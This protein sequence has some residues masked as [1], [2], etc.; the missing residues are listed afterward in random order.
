M[1]INNI[2][3]AIAQINA[4][5]GDLKGN[6]K[7]IT[8]FLN[9]GNKVGC[10]IILFPELSITGYPP[11]DLLL[12]KQFVKHQKII[13]H[14]IAQHVENFICIVGFVDSDD[15]SLY[16]A[17]AIIFQGQLQHVYRKI[18]L[19]NYSVFD[20][21]RYFEKG[22]NPCVVN[23]NNI[24]IGIS[25]CEDI[26]IPNSVSEASAFAGGAEIIVNISASPYSMEKIK[27]REQ[28]MKTRAQQCFS[29]IVYANLVGG[30]DELVFDGNSLIVDQYG[31][32]KATGAA[33]KQDFIIYDINLD[34]VRQNR[35]IKYYQ[36]VSEYSPHYKKIDNID[37]K[38]MKTQKKNQQSYKQENIKIMSLEEE[39]YFAL[40]LGLHDYVF[41]NG[42]T[43][44]VLGLSGGID[45]AL[46]ATIAA[47]AL[48]AKNVHCVL[49][50]SQYSSQGSV[51]DSKTLA[52]NLG[53]EYSVFP[54]KD[55]F[56][57]YLQL[58]EQIFSDL[59]SDI[60]EEN[61]QARI[62]GNIIMALSNKFGWLALATGN[63]SEVSVGYCTIYG[64]MVG[65]FAPLKDV[66]KTLVYGLSNYRNKKAGYD[67][68]PRSII[69]KAPSAELRP[70]QTDQDSLPPYEI[71]DH[72]L[73]LYIE[74]SLGY[75]E[76]VQSGHNIETVRQV[77]RL[78]DINEY[79]RRQ[80]APGTKITSLAFG[81]DRRMPIT[82]RF[83]GF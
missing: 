59:P 66:N 73:E 39:V 38:Y 67:I 27:E 16:N 76:I 47:D 8:T 58:F 6:K 44:V 53:L 1:T 75:E 49:M 28:L 31:I 68:I 41:K 77:I 78:V 37:I 71:L 80:A 19:P 15:I 21:E 26:W 83:R 54:I 9:K 36:Q 20:E 52:K 10:D 64:D 51:E 24:K 74:K 33:F 14:E 13:L 82:N 48:G 60:T 46:V 17:A 55:I 79:K 29:W 62:R 25:I 40:M 12:R 65:G 43:H 69:E 7:I 22:E 30:Q 32:T 42:F 81:K 4:T 50:P 56:T 70:D 11:E 57:H 63:K 3:V 45:S 18:Q 5:V 35:N 61:L 72:I 2:R 23:F 34:S